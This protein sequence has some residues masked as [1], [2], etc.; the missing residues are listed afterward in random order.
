MPAADQIRPR[1]TPPKIRY[2][3]ECGHPF[4]PTRPHQQFCRTKCRSDKHHRDER[5]GAE[6]L[7]FA[8]EW[9][10]KRLKGG[11]TRLTQMVDRYLAEDRDR[12]K[13]IEA[14]RKA[15]QP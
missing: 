8:L 6:L 1:G 9:R 11:F 3:Q 12:A 5:R 7:D 13:A 14:K 4:W 15:A 10:R 2:C